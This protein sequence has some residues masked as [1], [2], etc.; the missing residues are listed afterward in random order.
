VTFIRIS[1]QRES[2]EGD[3]E[4]RDA[5]ARRMR[6][7]LRILR[8]SNLSSNPASFGVRCRPLKALSKPSFLDKDL[9]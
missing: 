9:A 4:R 2:R 5:A 3:A 1:A 6:R 7:Q 8:K